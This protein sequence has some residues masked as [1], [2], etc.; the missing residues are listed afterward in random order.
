MKLL[1][2]KT[3]LLALPSGNHRSEMYFWLHSSV[4]FNHDGSKITVAP[5]AFLTKSQLPFTG[6]EAVKQV[7]I[8]ALSKV[9][10][11]SLAQDRTLCPVRALRIYIERT[12]QLR[13]NESLLF[14][15]FR[16]VIS[17]DI[18]RSTISGW[19]KSFV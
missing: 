10:D 19:I 12:K 4:F 18:C 15:S 14:I 2:Y 6:P 9:L 16:A 1:S 8:P 5:P 13:A 11:S 17:K 3:V 7:V